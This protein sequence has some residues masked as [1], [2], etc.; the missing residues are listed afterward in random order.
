MYWVP[1]LIFRNL[2]TI[3]FTT[4]ASVSTVMATSVFLGTH[5]CLPQNLSSLKLKLVLAFLY[6]ASKEAQEATP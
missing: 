1:S 2:I 3:R 4:Q 6:Q 5:I